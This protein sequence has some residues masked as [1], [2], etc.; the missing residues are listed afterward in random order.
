LKNPTGTVVTQSIFSE[1][2]TYDTARDAVGSAKLDP[3][4]SQEGRPPA[5]GDRPARAAR[6]AD[7]LI[8]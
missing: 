5:A 2:I 6:A 8:T 3:V 7:T 1:T 4:A